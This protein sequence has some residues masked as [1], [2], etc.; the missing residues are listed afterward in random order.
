MPKSS[1]S[2]F[3]GRGSGTVTVIEEPV[4][5]SYARKAKA[6]F[7]LTLAAVGLLAATILVGRWE[8]SL[9]MIGAGVVSL[10]A[11][12]LIGLVPAVLVAAVVAAWPIIRVFW[13]WMPELAITGALVAGWIELASHADMIIRF[14][15]LAA[16][17][18]IPA[19]VRPVRNWLWSWS[20]CLASR[21]RIRTCFSEFIVANR[22]GSLPLMLGA[23]PTPAG[24][25]LWVLL[26]PGMSIDIVQ[27]NT[28]KIAAACWASSVTADVA[29]PSN[30][31]LVRFDIKRRDPLTGTVASPLTVMFGN[32]IPGRKQAAP[33]PVALD[34]TDVTAD[35]VTPAPAKTAAAS[36]RPQWPHS[37]A[38]SG[39]TLIGTV[40]PND[41]K[42]D[43]DD[44]I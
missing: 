24:E 21:H 29:N 43:L 44:W 14:A 36:P 37:A 4:L 5:R 32:V 15:A 34:L 3:P 19:A 13:W 16:F 10:I 33:A 22:T 20:W 9:G 7:Y 12:L 25:R 38:S 27:D 39:D 35:D 6:V 41:K 26:R 2:G 28:A 40:V 31:A 42:E 23:R 18:A 8:H 1:R 17:F 30:S 11:G